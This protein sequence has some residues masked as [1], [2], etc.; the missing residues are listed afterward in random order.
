MHKELWDLFDKDLNHRGTFVRGAGM[1]PDGLYHKTVE[2]IPTDMAGT[3][4]LSR[5]SFR[6]SHGGGT[7]E[8]PAGSV[9]AGEN[10][11]DAAARELKE[12]TGLQAKKL[13]FLQRIR[14]PGM[15][16]YLYL[17]YIPDLSKQKVHINPAEVS[18]FRYV[19]FDEWMDLLTSSEFNPIRIRYYTERLYETIGKLVNYRINTAP[20]RGK[21]EDAPL[22]KT[23]SLH[24]HVP[25]KLKSTDLDAQHYEVSST[26]REAPEEW[27]P[28][29][30]R[31]DDGT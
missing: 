23:T 10:E 9:L 12:E 21:Q 15:F 18:G 24:S 7:L 4:L 25:S 6:K 14:T 19:Q 16:R 28:L 3:M 5:R 17:A 22:T 26:Y 11:I 27:E 31:G 13:Y 20:Q 2:V 30:M 8:F 29:Y 1:I